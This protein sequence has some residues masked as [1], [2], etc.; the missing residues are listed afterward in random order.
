MD[1]LVFAEKKSKAEQDKCDE[2]DRG[3]SVPKLAGVKTAK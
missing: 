3:D 2:V 1:V